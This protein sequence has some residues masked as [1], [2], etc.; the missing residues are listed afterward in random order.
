MTF[1]ELIDGLGKSLGIELT[2][3][4]GAAAVE[5]DGIPV[6]LQRASDDLLLVH[7]DLGEVAPENRDRVFAAA[8][9][10]NFLYQGT[11][12]ATLAV[13]SRDGHLHLQKYN[14]L[15][16]L[17]AEKAAADIA[18][19]A[20]TVNVWKKLVAETATSA[21]AAANGSSAPVPGGFMQV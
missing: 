6:V 10:A 20:E 17:D 7:A 3:E 8:M 12:G 19:F 9:E 1:G 2:D 18:R 5:V 14:W 15:D 16:R 13:D 11:G 21:P 4:G